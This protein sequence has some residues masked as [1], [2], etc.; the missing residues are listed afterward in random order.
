MEGVKRSFYVI[1]GLIGVMMTGVT[2][3]LIL[4]QCFTEINICLTLFC[5]VS[6]ILFFIAVLQ[7][8]NPEK[9]KSESKP[10]NEIVLIMKQTDLP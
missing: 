8:L 1:L 2:I 5:I 7:I 3:F 10:E 6:W 9:E 4:I